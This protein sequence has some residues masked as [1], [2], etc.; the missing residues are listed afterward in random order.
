MS[1]PMP[2]R[3]KCKDNGELVYGWFLEK[4]GKSYI[5]SDFETDCYDGENTD[6]YAT[7]WNEVDPETV[8][9]YIG[10]TDDNGV[11]LYS[12][13]RVKFTNLILGRFSDK[14][15]WAEGTVFYDE[16]NVWVY[17]QARGRWMELATFGCRSFA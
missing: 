2:Y 5:I 4:D 13:M 15:Q 9:Q 7:V 8:G 14:E 10:R 11:E 16:K 12:G 17:H 3:G 6:L 1:K